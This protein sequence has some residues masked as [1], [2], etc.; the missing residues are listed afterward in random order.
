MGKIDADENYRVSHD[1]V[2]DGLYLGHL[3]EQV[4]E[5]IERCREEITSI[6]I[7]ALRQ[8]AAWDAW[9]EVHTKRAIEKCDRALYYYSQLDPEDKAK[10]RKGVY[11]LCLEVDRR[12]HGSYSA[13]PPDP[14]D[15]D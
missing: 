10:W 7:Y 14:Y 5:C 13:P 11:A 3:Q 1:T 2:V 8:T 15:Y 4:K 9:L 6:D 12:L